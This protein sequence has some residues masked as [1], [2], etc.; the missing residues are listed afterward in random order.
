[1]IVIRCA[2]CDE[3]LTP[4]QRGSPCPKCGSRHETVMGADQANVSDA[5]A[6]LANLHYLNQEFDA[7]PDDVVEIT[8]DGQANVMLLD[9][10]NYE[11]YRKREPF[12]YYGGLAKYTPMRMVP[13]HLGKW[14][15]VVD[16]G[17]SAGSVR[18]GLLLRRGA[19]T[20]R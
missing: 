19:K 9:P 3:S 13:P 11:H 6:K 17:G 2:E 7:G 4:E 16:L 12:K 10:V 8:L 5:D 15:V 20:A 14:H 1:M 18:A